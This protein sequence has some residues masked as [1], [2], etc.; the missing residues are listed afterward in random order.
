MMHW[1]TG[2]WL[3]SSGLGRLVAVFPANYDPHNDDFP[4]VETHPFADF[5]LIVTK[6]ADKPDL[7]MLP[8]GANI[9]DFLC[10]RPD[11]FITGLLHQNDGSFKAVGQVKVAEGHDRASL[12]FADVNGNGRDDL[13]WIEEFSGDTWVWY[14]EG[15]DTSR[16]LGSAFHW[17]QQTEM[18][19]VGLA[20]GTCLFYTDLSGDFRADEHYVLESINNIA[21]TSF[22]PACGLSNVEGDDPEGVIDPKLPV[23]P[24]DP[25][26]GNDEVSEGICS[27]Q[28]LG[29][30][31]LTLKNT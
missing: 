28:F 8:L 17:R 24:E 6:R 13:L 9:A 31:Q 20:T 7:R 11:G 16:P 30:T 14:N 25:N 27:Y 3:T 22:S 18:A 2:L 29:T 23:R 5:G 26:N 21:E 19:Y 10:L 12:R 4:I 15:E 1:V